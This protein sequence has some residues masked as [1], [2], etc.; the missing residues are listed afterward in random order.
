VVKGSRVQVRSASLSALCSVWLCSCGA[1]ASYVIFLMSCV[2]QNLVILK[3]QYVQFMIWTLFI[4]GLY[5]SLVTL[6]I[7]KGIQ[8]I[9]RLDI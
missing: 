4:S 8:C 7:I 9:Y 2:Y 5:F 6:S 3:R 1:H